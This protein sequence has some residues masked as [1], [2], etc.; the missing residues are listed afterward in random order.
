VKIVSF[1]NETPVVEYMH[2]QGQL[3]SLRSEKITEDDFYSM[4]KS[5]VQNICP[6]TQLLDYT[7]AEV[8]VPPGG[9]SERKIGHN[10]QFLLLLLPRMSR[11]LTELH[12]VTY[13]QSGS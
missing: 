10:N 13:S 12:I 6:K 9:G 4:L 2:R 8:V 11:I 1:L 7:T 5:V 3:L